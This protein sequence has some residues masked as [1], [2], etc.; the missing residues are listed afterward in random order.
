LC[1]EGCRG[2]HRDNDINLE[3]DE[4]GRGFRVALIAA[5]CPAILNREVAT[6]DPSEFTQPLHKSGGPLAP[7]HR[8]VHTHAP[9]GRP[10]RP[11]LP[12]CRKRPGDRTG[13][14]RHELAPSQLIGSHSFPSHSTA[15]SLLRNERLARRSNT[16]DLNDHLTVLRPREMRSS[17]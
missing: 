17:W 12:S 13:E 1:R 16:G 2:S 9:D 8:R 15:L 14:Q 3:P 11:P 4:L 5:L 6:I 7:H 10:P